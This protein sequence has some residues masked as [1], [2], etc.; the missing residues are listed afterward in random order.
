[1]T[2]SEKSHDSEQNSRWLA[3]ERKNR[4]GDRVAEKRMTLVFVVVGVILLILLLYVLRQVSERPNLV[5][6]G[7]T[8][9]CQW[10]T[11]PLPYCLECGANLS[12]QLRCG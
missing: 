3:W 2:L 9:A 1:M 6:K 11:D 8:A 7:P 12:S 5:K 10:R 4:R